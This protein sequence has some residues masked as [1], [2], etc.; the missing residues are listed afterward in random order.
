MLL[1]ETRT[2]AQLHFRRYQPGLEVLV[3]RTAIHMLQATQ[4]S[5]LFLIKFQ[6]DGLM[7]V[8]FAF[9]AL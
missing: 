3:A 9:G 7:S 6:F 5:R 4:M 1:C 8:F 2:H